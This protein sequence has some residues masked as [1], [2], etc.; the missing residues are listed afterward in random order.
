MVGVREED[1][2]R[3]AFEAGEDVCAKVLCLV[4]F[5]SIRGCGGVILR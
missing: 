4:R 1:G 3:G 5:T 2:V